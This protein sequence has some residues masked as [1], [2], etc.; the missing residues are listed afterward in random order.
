[1]FFA[2]RVDGAVVGAF[3]S[4]Q[5]EPARRCMAP[6]ASVGSPGRS[7]RGRPERPGGCLGR[8]IEPQDAKSN[9]PGTPCRSVSRPADRA[10]PSWTG[11]VE[12]FRY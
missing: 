4:S 12:Q 3:V 10:P 11:M 9:Q 7:E 6:R 5:V 2:N 8:H 1:M